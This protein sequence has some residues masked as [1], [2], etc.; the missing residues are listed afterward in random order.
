MHGVKHDESRTASKERRAQ[1]VSCTIS[2]RRSL[3]SFAVRLLNT[4]AIPFDHS[5]QL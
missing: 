5:Y 3:G 4:D 2:S 1:S